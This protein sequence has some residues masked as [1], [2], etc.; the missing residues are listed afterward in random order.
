MAKTKT[1]HYKGYWLRKGRGWYVTEGQKKIP[2]TDEHGNHLKDPGTPKVDLENAHAHY[3][4]KRGKTEQLQAV[5]NGLLV[6][7][8]VQEYLAH[9]KDD[10]PSPRSTSGRIPV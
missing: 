3:L 4:L 8:A 7:A 2:L 10:N 1:K 6:V 9:V 5:G